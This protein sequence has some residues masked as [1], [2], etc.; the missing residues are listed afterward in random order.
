MK[1]NHIVKFLIKKNEELYHYWASFLIA[2]FIL[3]VIK[4]IIIY[5]FQWYQD[6]DVFKNILTTFLSD[7]FYFLRVS[8]FVFLSYI[9]KNRFVRILLNLLSFIWI[10]LF[11]ADLFY[12]FLLWT[13]ITIQEIYQSIN[14]WFFLWRSAII[15]F[16]LL[17]LL[18]QICAFHKK[19]IRKVIISI[20]IWFLITYFI[21]W[22]YLITKV[23]TI[24]NCISDNI[25]VRS[26][27]FTKNKWSDDITF[28]AHRWVT[29]WWIP[30]NSLESFYKAKELWADGIE[31]DVVQTNDG[32]YIVLHDEELSTSKEC[33]DKKVSDFTYEYIYN[34]CKLI[35]WE[36]YLRLEDVLRKIDW[37]FEYYFL[38][39]KVF[40]EDLW[41]E[42]TRNIIDIVKSLNMQNKVIFY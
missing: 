23:W 10:L 15:W 24:P 32:E 2:L 41:E 12:I 26:L 3:E 40:N 27:L 37:L 7:W 13:R 34:N 21:I 19:Q 35:N 4:L 1:R 28:I 16:I 22:I 11:C 17:C 5:H 25:I 31:F 6:L 30:E 18:L 20:L 33:S 14:L 8:I 36:K 39:I 38:E 42:I 29:Q 9:T